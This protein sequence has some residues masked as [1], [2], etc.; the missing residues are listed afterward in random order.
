LITF[1]FR[2]VAG[3]VCP[4]TLLRL[5]T[6]YVTRLLLRCFT[7]VVHVYVALRWYYTVTTPVYVPVAFDLIYV[8]CCHLVTFTLVT[9]V[10]LRTFD[11][12]RLVDCTTTFVVYRCTLFALVTPVTL[13]GCVYVYV[14]VV[15]YLL[16]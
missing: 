1:T 12:P 15:V 6:R 2:Y 9:V 14:A 3:F 11:S 7:F 8:R 4:V 13:Y 10:A 5:F 16:V